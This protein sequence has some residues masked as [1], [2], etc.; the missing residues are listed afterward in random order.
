MRRLAAAAGARGRVGGGRCVRSA[1]SSLTPLGAAARDEDAQQV[2]GG[3]GAPSSSLAGSAAPRVHSGAAHAR[4]PPTSQLAHLLQLLLCSW[5]QIRHRCLPLP[6]PIQ[7]VLVPLS[8]ESRRAARCVMRWQGSQRGGDASPPRPPLLH[9]A[10][11]M[12]GKRTCL[13]ELNQAVAQPLTS[14][15]PPTDDGFT[16]LNKAALA[17]AL[18]AQARLVIAA[19][20]PCCARAQNAQQAQA[21]LWIELQ[22]RAEPQEGMLL[23][24]VVA[25][26][27]KRCAPAGQ[28]NTTWQCAHTM[29]R[30][31][32]S[33]ARIIPRPK[34]GANMWG[35]CVSAHPRQSPQRDRRVLNKAARQR[36]RRLLQQDH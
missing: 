8:S 2:G 34:K 15:V 30:H 18:G 29:F 11:S 13:H 25:N 36:A 23:L 21:D 27:T 24:H 10:P 28:A 3:G 33:P 12:G 32:C 16:E 35:Q 19:A 22:Q 6:Q 7:L 31:V 26:A 9:R 4:R 1:H 17:G 14:N 5:A 20:P